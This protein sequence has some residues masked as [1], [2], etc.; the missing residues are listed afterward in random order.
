[1]RSVGHGPSGPAEALS[2]LVPGGSD[3]AQ[4]AVFLSPLKRTTRLVVLRRG[5]GQSVNSLT[6]NVLNPR[7]KP[8]ETIVRRTTNSTKTKHTSYISHANHVQFMSMRHSD[9]Y[10]TLSCPSCCEHLRVLA[11]AVF[12]A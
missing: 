8:H 12:G 1:M 6:C 5:R 10:K 4:V 2:R 11:R 7:T 3:T 9:T